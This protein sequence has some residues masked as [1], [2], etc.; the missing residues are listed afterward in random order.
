MDLLR[1][2]SESFN[3]KV[4]EEMEFAQQMQQ[5]DKELED[6]LQQQSAS[7]AQLKQQIREDVLAQSSTEVILKPCTSFLRRNCKKEV[8]GERW[9]S[10]TEP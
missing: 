7:L 5:Q 6:L 4:E 9:H 10:L 8:H 2:N 1:A 3:K